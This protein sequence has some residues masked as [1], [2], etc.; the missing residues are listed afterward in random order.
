MSPNNKLQLEDVRWLIWL[1]RGWTY[2]LGSGLLST[3]TSPA[4]ATP[5]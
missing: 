4:Q 5:V 2:W 1:W 3:G